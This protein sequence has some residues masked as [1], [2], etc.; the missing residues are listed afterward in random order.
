[1]D[2]FFRLRDSRSRL[3]PS[4]VPQ[5]AIRRR[6]ESASLRFLS[7][8]RFWSFEMLL[9]LLRFDSIALLSERQL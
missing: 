1:M 2:S 6:Q 4:T 5:D 8:I 7:R 9:I 3:R